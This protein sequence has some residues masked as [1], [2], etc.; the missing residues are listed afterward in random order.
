[1]V[2]GD[3]FI[4]CTI[5]A[6]LFTEWQMDIQADL[7]ILIQIGLPHRFFPFFFCKGFKIPIGNGWITCVPGK[8]YIVF[9]Q[10]TNQVGP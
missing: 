3:P 2:L 5:G 7:S 9:I 6:K 8:G 4:T 1:M 10:K